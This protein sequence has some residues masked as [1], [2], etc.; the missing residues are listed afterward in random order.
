MLARWLVVLMKKVK[1][2]STSRSPNAE[3]SCTIEI[4]SYQS[5]VHYCTIMI[6]C[7]IIWLISL[8]IR[9]VVVLLHPNFTSQ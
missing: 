5:S 7:Q 1:S 2:G 8:I 4:V 6:R 9:M 3:P